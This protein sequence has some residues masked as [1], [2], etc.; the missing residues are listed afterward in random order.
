MNIDEDSNWEIALQEPEADATGVDADMHELPH[1]IKCNMTFIPIYNFLPR[2]SS[3]AP[4]I[5][6]D[7][8][9]EPKKEKKQ[10]LK[11]TGDRL[12]EGKEKVLADIERARQEAKKAE[13][14]AKNK[15]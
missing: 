2:K 5:G 4:F 3:E 7:G 6:I 8:M 1:L 14:A 11:G 15:K 13:E 10:W 12:K 9:S